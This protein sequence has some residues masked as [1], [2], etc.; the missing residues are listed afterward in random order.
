MKR[1]LFL[2]A[3]SISTVAGMTALAGCSSGNDDSG[4]GSEGTNASGEA[5][6]TSGGAGGASTTQASSEGTAMT[7]SGTSATAGANGTA[8][9][10]GGSGGSGGTTT[11]GMHTEGSSYYFDPIGVYVEPGTTVTFEIQSGAHSSTS[12]TTDN[13]S[14]SERRIPEGAES[15]DSGTISTGGSFDHTFETEGTYDYFCIPHKTLGM[16]GRIVVGSPGG[17]AEGSM[18]P[19]GDVPKS[20]A[21]VDQGSIAY[22]DFS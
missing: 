3:A 8:A 16:V 6:Q 5:T 14:V 22:D 17:P 21:I 12:Y 7:S 1:R 2:K 19:D 18:P 9:M 15:W 10:S 11:V 13:P 4:N 20:Q